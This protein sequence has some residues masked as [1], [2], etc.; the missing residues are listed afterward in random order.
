VPIFA[1]SGAKTTDRHRFCAWTV[2][3]GSDVKGCLVL[4]DR[5][6]LAPDPA[7]AL[8]DLPTVCLL[9]RLEAARWI[10]VQSSSTHGARK[11][12]KVF[13][14]RKPSSKKPYF[15]CLLH[16]E[17]LV[18]SGPSEWK[19]SESQAFFKVLFSNPSKAV[20]GRS[21]IEYRQLLKQSSEDAPVAAL[22]D[23]PLAPLP[24]VR[25]R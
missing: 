15:L 20:P 17:S 1:L 8:Q 2:S 12:A 11:L 4:S 3:D 18:K 14:A 10:P 23:R 13:D 9:D 21:A 7:L 24:P 5:R 22:A 16:L 6:A 25:S 19:S